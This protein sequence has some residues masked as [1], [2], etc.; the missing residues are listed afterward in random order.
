MEQWELRV[1][2]E[3][4]VLEAQGKVLDCSNV[5]DIQK[6]H[7][8]AVLDQLAHRCRYLMFCQRMHSFTTQFVHSTIKIQLI[9]NKVNILQDMAAKL[10]KEIG[11][12]Q[13]RM[14]EL[15]EQKATFQT[16]LQVGSRFASLHMLIHIQIH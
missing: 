2:S 13:Q 12:N 14:A 6:S 1:G 9:F 15:A 7:L 5:V 8:Y 3:L 4:K 10:K 16:Q 11:E